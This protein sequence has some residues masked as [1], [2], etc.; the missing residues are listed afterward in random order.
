[1][2]GH[3]HPYTWLLL[4]PGALTLAAAGAAWRRRRAP[5]GAAFIAIMT[6]LSLWCFGYGFE[7][8]SQELAAKIAW[9]QIGRASCRER[10]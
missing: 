5:G 9:N 8:A 3:W 6:A 2:S 7:W 1:M 10:V 4:I